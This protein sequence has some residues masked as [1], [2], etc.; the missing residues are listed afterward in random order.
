MLFADLELL[1]RIERLTMTI[2]LVG[3]LIAAAIVFVGLRI[4]GRR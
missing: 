4:P 3:F 1:L 2:G